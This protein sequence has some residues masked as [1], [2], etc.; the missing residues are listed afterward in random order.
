[1]DEHIASTDDLG[2]T[3]SVNIFTPTKPKKPKT[4]VTAP[5]V[6]EAKDDGVEEK[7]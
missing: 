7:K 6:V 1:M 4:E 5:V 2:Y 3:R